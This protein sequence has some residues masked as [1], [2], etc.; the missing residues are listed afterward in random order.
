MAIIRLH[1]KTNIVSNSFLSLL[2]LLLL[3]LFLNI[4]FPLHQE[5]YRFNYSKV[6]L[7]D[8]NE[9]I[10]MKISEDGYWRFYV[11]N[12]KI[13][14]LLIDSI[15]TFEDKY[16]FHHPGINVF[17]IIR[18]VIS[19]LSGNRIG[20]STITMQLVRIVEPKDR[21]YLNKLV[22]IFRALQLE[23]NY[24]KEKILNLYLNKAPYGGNIEGVRAAAYFY[25]G[26]KL[27]NLT[28]SE[29]AILTTIP[30]NPNHNRPDRQ[31]NL[32]EKR[33]HVL[34]R[35][36]KRNLINEEQY[37][38]TQKET[39]SS[40]RKQAKFDCIQYTNSILSQKIGTDIA[41]SIDFRL[42]K[43]IQK[44]LKSESKKY[45]EKGL[46]NSAC[47]VIDNHNMQAK[48]YVASND[49]SDKSHGGQNDGIL[50]MKS[51]GSTLKP[52]VYALALDEGLITLKKKLLDIPLNYKGYIP[53]NYNQK[54]HGQISTEESLKLSL[55]VPVVD[56]Q[57]QLG[58]NSLYEFLERTRTPVY[59]P[60]NKYGLS[61]AV[62]GI[63]I[64][65]LNL[66][67]LYTVLANS[68]MLKKKDGS[69]KRMFSEEA[70][71]LVSKTLADGYRDQF[72]GYWDSSPN[73]P[74]IAF[75]TGTSADAKHLY[76]IGYTPEYTI[77]VWFG[78][79]NGSKPKSDSTG[80]G[81]ASNT[82]IEIFEHINKQVKPLTWYEVPKGLE[83]R[84]I[85][86][87]YVKKD[88]C[89]ESK[90]EDFVIKDKES[91]CMQLNAQKI[92]YLLESK[93]YNSSDEIL[94]QDCYKHL[95]AKPPVIISPYN[96]QVFLFNDLIPKKFRTIKVTCQSYSSKANVELYLNNKLIK[97]NSYLQ[98]DEGS[99]EL[100]CFTDVDKYDVVS[101]KV[102]KEY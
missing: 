98:L 71:Y 16:F 88:I 75:K 102:K 17:S 83:K 100:E 2:F 30:K 80:L 101:F 48:A 14:D 90:V 35:L 40:D 76:T 52:F 81:I 4:V 43:Y 19:N 12:E 66:V 7:S 1:L 92:K 55:N 91:K 93:E 65:L 82:L 36:L 62:G 64:S 70:S 18:A 10:R 85:C 11:T 25:F 94:N 21:T 96:E 45:S 8:T 6:F 5:K 28:I 26:K 53:K 67:K 34:D 69:T 24:T 74:S 49:F 97:N 57:D 89:N 73:K 77:G 41:T 22:E 54:Y 42:Q 84:K 60:K 59:Y 99:Y 79:F 23:M 50:M 78:N 47:L 13:P 27:T 61:I 46:F 3:F 87:S 20:A 44:L 72:I 33:N 37:I 39:I 56:L 51:P 63:D 29:M 86:R 9:P 68:G 95:K 31:K 58:S 15:I 32:I 38:R